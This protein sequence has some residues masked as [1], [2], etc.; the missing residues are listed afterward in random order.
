LKFFIRNLKVRFKIFFLLSIIISTATIT[1][2]VY[3]NL[4]VKKALEKNIESE[5]TNTTQAILDMVKTGAA[6]SIRNRLRAIAEKNHDILTLL[7]TRFLKG[8]ISEDAA[9]QLASEILLSQTIGSS[10][11]IFCME[12]SGKLK[13]HPNAAMINTD[14]SNHD[15]VK[16]QIGQKQ[17]YIE[18][19]WANPGTPKR[20]KALYMVYFKPWDWIISVTAYKNEFKEL[21]NV[22]DFREAVTSRKF[23]NSG[24]SHILDTKGNL[25]LHPK[26]EGSNIY[27][28][29]DA[30][31]RKFIQEV[32]TLKNGKIIYPWKNPGEKTSRQKLVIFNYMKEF[33]WII[34]SSSYLDEFYSPLGNIR[35]AITLTTILT[36]IATLIVT[37]WISAFVT[38]FLK[39]FIKS[40]EQGARGDFAARLP[41]RSEDE[42]GK[43]ARYFNLFMENLETHT[44]KLEGLVQSR[45]RE[46]EQE[47]L[48]RKRVEIALERQ[49]K[50]LDTF[51]DTIP[52]PGFLKD[53]NGVYIRCNNAFAQE[54]LGLGPKDVE[55]K[56]LFNFNEKIPLELA[57]LYKKKDDD[58][59]KHGGKQQYEGRVKCS[60]NTL[61]DFQF[62]KACFYDTEGEIAGIAGVMMDL[63]EIHRARSK[64]Q[65]QSDK[66]HQ[67]NLRLSEL[68]S[69]DS[70]TDIANR[71]TFQ[72]E[73]EKQ[74]SL[75]A[76]NRTP[77]S[78]V[79]AD[80]DNFKK[81]NDSFGH[82]AGDEVIK[83]IAMLITEGSRT[84]DT[85]ARY[86]GEEFA[87]ILPSTDMAG[88]VTM[89]N[90]FCHKVQTHQWKQRKV[91]LSIGLATA[92]F[93]VVDKT[94]IEK[95]GIS[96]IDRADRALYA[97]K[98][99]GRNKVTHEDELG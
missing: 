58:L 17:G 24:Y 46:L 19:E 4:I 64:I 25:I 88:A 5:L 47:V 12:S 38:N 95:T 29:I 37:L 36:L 74:I 26:L 50:I 40:F 41:V 82:T 30:E 27:D 97:S 48:E 99:G 8:Q 75:A 42:V 85:V 81:Y 56:S 70:L 45:T 83:K 34:S 33:D 32:C 60:D 66:L 16:T 6:I 52:C 2:G 20:L 51:I 22:N 69:L 15:F 71:R 43:L 61:L 76:R 91:T 90:R 35:T 63:S 9:K 21:V 59:I 14:I 79:M 92:T 89:G 10:G 77:L 28:T 11:Y 31:G 53:K 13:V 93:E 78:L 55:G 87:V 39:T 23:G 98:A 7:Y 54:I 49:M 57:L 96:F 3:V 44:K 1:E 67:A 62:Y 86:G 68:A 94:T 84:T 80:I 73:L 72:K 65:E 18:Y